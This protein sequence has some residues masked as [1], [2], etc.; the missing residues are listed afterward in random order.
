[1][2]LKYLTSFN[3]S[4]NNINIGSVN[5]NTNLYM[6]NT[7]NKN[8]PDTLLGY[9]TYS[10][11]SNPTSNS[12]IES[13]MNP[14]TATLTNPTFLSS[15]SP[16]SLSSQY[17]STNK[18]ENDTLQRCTGVTNDNW[19]DFLV[20]YYNPSLSTGPEVNIPRLDHNYN[21]L[22]HIFSVE[23]DSYKI[24]CSC[25]SPT[26]CSQLSTENNSSTTTQNE[27]TQEQVNKMNGSVVS[28]LSVTIENENEN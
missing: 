28:E 14:L 5:F 27:K 18:R 7:H 25:V 15:L 12:W 23:S 10:S 9:P 19:R 22:N 21:V 26:G 4:P 3:Y 20:N 16:N 8:N 1:M 11:T 6:N 17:L 2:N 24:S 13:L